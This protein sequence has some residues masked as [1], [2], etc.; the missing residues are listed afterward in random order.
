LSAF[1]LGSNLP[2]KL[3]NNWVL[4][5]FISSFGVLVLRDRCAPFLPLIATSVPS[6]ARS[7]RL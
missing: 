3:W 6:E 5:I 1:A 2:F 7:C 4:A